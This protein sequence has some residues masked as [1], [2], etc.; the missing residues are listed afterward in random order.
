MKATTF[1]CDLNVAN[2][3]GNVPTQHEVTCGRRK[4]QVS[5][6]DPNPTG[7]NA[8][9]VKGQHYIQKCMCSIQSKQKHKNRIYDTIKVQGSFLFPPFYFMLSICS[10]TTFHYTAGYMAVCTVYGCMWVKASRPRRR[11]VPHTH[12]LLR[13]YCMGRYCILQGYIHTVHAV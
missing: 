4:M 1:S 5:K 6:D 11:T 3:T 7:H 10:W 9:K 13:R 12:T 2:V 8:S